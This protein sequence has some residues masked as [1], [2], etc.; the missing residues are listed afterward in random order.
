[1]TCRIPPIVR[2]REDAP[3]ELPH[4]LLLCDDRSDGLMKWLSGKKE[5]MRKIYNFNLMK[6]G[7]HISGWCLENSQKILKRRL[8][9]MRI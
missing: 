5:E 1:M 7:G 2:I 6:E 9:L 3:V 8:H 4:V